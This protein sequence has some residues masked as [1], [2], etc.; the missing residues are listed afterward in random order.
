M[1]VEEVEILAVKGCCSTVC[2]K[3]FDETSSSDELTTLVID[4]SKD[5]LETLQ[6]HESLAGIKSKCISKREHLVSI[7]KRIFPN[8]IACSSIDE[9]LSFFL[10]FQILAYR[11]K[12]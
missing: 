7:K 9:I 10:W 12:E 3:S 4:P 5:E 2:D 8:I 1:P 6:G 11:R